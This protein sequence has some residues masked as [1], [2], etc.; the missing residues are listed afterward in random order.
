MIAVVTWL[1]RIVKAFIV[2]SVGGV[3]RALLCNVRL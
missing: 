3:E 2:V 1:G